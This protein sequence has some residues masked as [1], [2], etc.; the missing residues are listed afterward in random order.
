MSITDEKHRTNGRKKGMEI[1]Q[2]GSQLQ[3]IL[4]VP[5]L[6]GGCIGQT[7]LNSN[8]E[9]K[10]LEELSAVDKQDMRIIFLKGD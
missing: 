8:Q 1:Q 7:E 6:I 9:V 2:F 3:G 10:W 4:H 5:C